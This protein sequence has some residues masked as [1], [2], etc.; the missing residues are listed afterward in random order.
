V[1]T[2]FGKFP[3]FVDRSWL[4]GI[5]QEGAAYVECVSSRGMPQKLVSRFTGEPVSIAMR[6]DLGGRSKG[7]N[8]YYPSPEMHEDAARVLLEPAKNRI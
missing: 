7:I 6:E 3:Q 8:D 4:D 1:E 2:L 5:H